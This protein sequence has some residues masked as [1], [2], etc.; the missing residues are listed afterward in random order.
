[1]T[2]LPK[3]PLRRFLKRACD[4]FL[5][6]DVVESLRLLM[7]RSF[8]SFGVT[9]ISALEPDTVA[10]AAYG[11]QMSIALH[12]RASIALFGSEA[13]AMKIP[14]RVGADP[15]ATATKAGDGS[16]SDDDDASSVGIGAASSF[17]ACARV[18][19]HAC[20]ASRRL[21]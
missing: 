13:A 6:N 3:L 14:L 10:V 12:S 17:S 2:L 15:P 9:A 19:P 5:L 7:L 11:Q 8:G 16:S 4:A 1:M 21:G 20:P 18:C